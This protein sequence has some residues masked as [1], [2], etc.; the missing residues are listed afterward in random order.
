MRSAFQS[1]LRPASARPTGCK[2]AGPRIPMICRMGWPW[3]GVIQISGHLIALTCLTGVNSLTGSLDASY[4]ALRS[5]FIDEARLPVGVRVW[6]LDELA[7][8]AQRLGD[9]RAAEA[10]LLA[11]LRAAPHDG[12]SKAAYADLLLREDRNTE[13][14]QLLR[15]D[16]SQDNLLLRLGHCRHAVAERARSAFQ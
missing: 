13:V 7:D 12:Y 2:L 10:H 9:D 16:E 3:P 4:H 11:A 6:V 15:E 8:M 5:V 14:L 1:R